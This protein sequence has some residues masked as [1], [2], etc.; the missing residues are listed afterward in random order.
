MMRSRRVWVGAALMLGA[1]LCQT[2]QAESD[3]YAAL[4]QLEHELLDQFVPVLSD[5]LAVNDDELRGGQRWNDLSPDQR[6]RIRERYR[7]FQELPP[8]QQARIRERHEW[9]K[10]L[11]PGERR[12]LREKWKGM[13]PQE[14]KQLRKEL[15]ELRKHKKEKHSAHKDRN[16]R[17][18]Q[19]KLPEWFFKG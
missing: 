3:R 15:K 4:T 14:R 12:E 9:F 13:T 6:E 7:R 17:A 5:Y 16:S 11:P 10:S 1:A 2:A 18:A 19:I 8:D